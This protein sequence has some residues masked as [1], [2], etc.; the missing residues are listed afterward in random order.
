VLAAAIATIAILLV[1]LPL[2]SRSALPFALAAGFTCSTL[3][4][5]AWYWRARD[6]HRSF[7]AWLARP[8]IILLA[9]LATVLPYRHPWWWGIE[10][11]GFPPNLLVEH[12][13]VSLHPTMKSLRSFRLDEE[14]LVDSKYAEHYLKTNGPVL[15]RAGATINSQ[16]RG[17][18]LRILSLTP[19]EEDSTGVAVERF[20][21]GSRG[22]ALGLW[23]PRTR[24]TVRWTLQELPRGS[25]Y[26]ASNAT[27]LRDAPFL[28]TETVQL[29][30]ID[31][32]R[33]IVVALL[34]PAAAGFRAILAPLLSIWNLREWV[35][36]A[37]GAVM[38]SVIGSVFWPIV[39]N[40][41]KRPIERSMD[42]LSE[43]TTSSFRPGRR[44]RRIPKPRRS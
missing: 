24:A 17:P 8:S 19:P 13:D 38:G 36:W 27:V 15:H 25:F 9:I 41:L 21:D 23:Y 40:R 6:R 11:Y 32:E 12:Y 10:P 5:G 22:R 31:P 20:P 26:A 2:G 14:W 33:S 39:A 43:A 3:V 44:R 28:D 42:G 35:F 34:I 4:M 7:W 29:E 30:A 16:R 37:C 18:F 1:L